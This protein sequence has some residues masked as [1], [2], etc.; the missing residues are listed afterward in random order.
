MP[1]SGK[2]RD[3]MDYFLCLRMSSF[4]FTSEKNRKTYTCIFL[5]VEQKSA[6]VT[7]HCLFHFPLFLLGLFCYFL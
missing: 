4:I 7:D 2:L 5:V 3:L 1:K 6:A